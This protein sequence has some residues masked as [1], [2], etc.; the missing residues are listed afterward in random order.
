MSIISPRASC[1]EGSKAA[2]ECGRILEIRKKV[3]KAK[4]YK[5]VNCMGNC[6]FCVNKRISLSKSVDMMAVDFGCRGLSN[7]KALENK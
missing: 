3:K 5:A 4:E 1:L 7:F 6:N 2:M